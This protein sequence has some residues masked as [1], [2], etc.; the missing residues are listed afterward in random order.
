MT[1]WN[2]ET[3]ACEY[4]DQATA[5]LKAYKKVKLRAN[6]QVNLTISSQKVKFLYKFTLFKKLYPGVED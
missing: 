5:Q 4:T 1:F 2:L 6:G 3:E